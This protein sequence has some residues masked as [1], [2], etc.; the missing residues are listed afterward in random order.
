[1]VSHEI[2]TPLSAILSAANV[3][4]RY[5]NKRPESVERFAEVI[6]Q[7][8]RRLTR[9]I[10]NLLDLAKIEAGQVEWHFAPTPWNELCARCRSPS[11]RWSASATWSSRWSPGQSR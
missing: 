2:R 11:R 9:L 3:L 5:G 6:H 8:G 1:M 4:L 7:E 10:N